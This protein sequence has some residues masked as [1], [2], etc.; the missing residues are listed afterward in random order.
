MSAAVVGAAVGSAL[1]GFWSDRSGRKSSL[2]IADVFFAVGAIVMALASDA[3]TLIL[4]I[5]NFSAL[6]QHFLLLDCHS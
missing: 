5:Y 2:K 3:T 4:G 6:S 1:G